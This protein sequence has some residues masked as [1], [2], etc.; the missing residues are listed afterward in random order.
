MIISR[1]IYDICCA[2]TQREKQLFPGNL[3]YKLFLLFRQAPF[4]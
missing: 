2:V 3:N 1:N 4:F